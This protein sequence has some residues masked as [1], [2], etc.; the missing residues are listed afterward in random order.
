M[1]QSLQLNTLCMCRQAWS[2]QFLPSAL[3]PVHAVHEPVASA[4]LQKLQAA[5]QWEAKHQ[6]INV[7]ASM[8][9]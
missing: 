3:Q 6:Y 4:E 2:H 8:R 1:Q 7:K 9:T 5:L